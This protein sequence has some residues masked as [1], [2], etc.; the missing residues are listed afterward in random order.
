MI[1]S[2]KKKSP[3]IGIHG[4]RITIIVSTQ[5]KQGQM[6]LECF[7]K[8]DSGIEM[9]YTFWLRRELDY[10]LKSFNRIVAGTDS[11]KIRINDLVGKKVFI[12]IQGVLYYRGGEQVKDIHGE[13]IVVFRVAPKFYIYDDKL[14]PHINDSY[15]IVTKYL[16]GE[17]KLTY[18]Q[19]NE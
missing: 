2:L 15:F 10:Q 1:I 11:R 8:T 13:N 6:G 7:F 4:A 3:V 16:D 14:R 17:G 18:E 5:D 12:V 19:N 9:S